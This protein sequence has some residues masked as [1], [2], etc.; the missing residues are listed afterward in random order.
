MF[1][2]N[3]DPVPILSIGDDGIPP[4]GTFSANLVFPDEQKLFSES[5]HLLV[6]ARIAEISEDQKETT[7]NF[8]IK[9]PI[10]K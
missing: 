8:I 4:Q 10:R 1:Q 2:T 6:T 5:I 7:G 3:Y 9:L